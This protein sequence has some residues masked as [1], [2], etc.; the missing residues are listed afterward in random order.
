MAI[1]KVEKW[2]S[3]PSSFHM[4]LTSKEK[5]IVIFGRMKKL[6]HAFLFLFLLSL[7]FTALAQTKPAFKKVKAFYLEKA[8]NGSKSVSYKEEEHFLMLSGYSVP[9]RRVNFSYALCGKYHEV[10]IECPYPHNCMEGE[11][12][13]VSV[14]FASIEDCKSFIELLSALKEAA[15]LVKE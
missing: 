11:K 8:V 7:S 1:I 10:F 15:V 5:G 9:I 3:R 6:P 2:T 4:A 13:N 12:G 14:R